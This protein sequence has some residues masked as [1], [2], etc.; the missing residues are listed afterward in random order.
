MPGAH[1]F[2]DV[3]QALKAHIIVGEID[4]AADLPVC[5][6]R[7]A[8]AA[9]L[10]DSFE[11]G[12]DVDAIAKNIVVID[13]NVTDVNADTKF[14]PVVRRHVGILRSHIAL[15]FDRASRRIHR[16]GKL[17]QH[18]VARGLDD[19]AP[20]LDDL[21]IEKSFS[22][23]L[24]LAE[25]ALFIGAHEPAVTGDICRQNSRQSPFHALVGQGLPQIGA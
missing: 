4:L 10:R 20:M 8:D 23:C 1:R 17:D 11:A 22:E 18:A 25:R 16:T 13:D 3:L 6:V 7:D 14:D 5:V 12:G 15:N 21:R 2:D 19:A 24:Q 9:R